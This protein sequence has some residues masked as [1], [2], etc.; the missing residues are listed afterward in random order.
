[1]VFYFRKLTISLQ[2][3]IDS[4][5]TF[6]VTW[7]VCSCRHVTLKFPDGYRIKEIYVLYYQAIQ[8]RV[9]E[10]SVLCSQTDMVL[11]LTVSDVVWLFVWFFHLSSWQCRILGNFCLNSYVQGVVSA[12][13]HLSVCYPKGIKEPYYLGVKLVRLQCQGLEMLISLLPVCLCVLLRQAGSFPLLLTL[14]PELIV[15]CG[16]QEARI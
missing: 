13:V 14:A 5:T 16:V 3:F 11:L 2:L 6:S 9:L 7:L 10:D 15:Q 8:C 4:Q 12:L 1:V